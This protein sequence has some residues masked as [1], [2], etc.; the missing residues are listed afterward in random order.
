MNTLLFKYV[1]EVEKSRSISQA[2]ENL[3][4]AQPNLSKAIREVEETLGF[5]VF[6]RTPKG[7]IPTAQGQE[8]LTI[9]RNIVAQLEKIEAIAVGGEQPRR[10]L[11]ISIPRASYIA[12]GF[13]RFARE[14]DREDALELQVQE[15]NAMQTIAS[16]ASGLCSMGVIRYRPENE[17]YF[18]DYLAD[19]GLAHEPVWE[20][21][22]RL[23]FSARHPLASAGEIQ[24]HALLPFTEIV[25]GDE[26]VPYV[27]SERP[28]PP[29]ESRRFVSLCERANQFELLMQL[30]NTYMWVSPVPEP[31]LE[32][33][34]LVQRRCAGHTRRFRDELVYPVG[35]TF[36]AMER[37]FVDKLFEAKNAVAFGGE[38]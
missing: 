9:A 25:H 2:A 33:C 14:H 7:V 38:G 17:H 34:H 21:D 26:T 35:Y 6:R 37:A 29:T 24:E 16:I 4:M 1:L 13:I 23:L 5:P 30:D 18:L 31:T 36:T 22:Y 12:D 32:R 28:L 8:F 15:T 3:F 20:S 10:S 27:T 19:K 11:R